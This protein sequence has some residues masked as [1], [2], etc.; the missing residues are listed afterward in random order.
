MENQFPEGN[1]LPPEEPNPRYPTGGRELLFFFLILID[2]LLLCNSVIFGGF[3]LGFAIFAGLS[4]LLAAGYLLLC[5]H[6]FC[7]YSG[8]LLGLSLM[9]CAGFA[10]SN[11]SF[12]KLILF[13]FLLLSSNLGL[14][15][16]AGQNRWR[17]GGFL[18]LLDAFRAAFAMGLGRL[19]KSMQGLVGAFR[20]S[21]AAG[22]KGGAVLIGLV[23]ALP[24]LAIVVSLLVSADAAFDALVSLLPKGNGHEIF[25]TVLLGSLL[26]CW[27]YTRATALHH[28][29]RAE[30]AKGREGKGLNALTV[31]TVLAAL[32]LVYCVYLFSQL[33]YFSGGFSGILPEGYS[34]AEYARRGFFEMAWLC[35]VNLAVI[36]LSVG[37]VKKEK[38]APL[39]TRLLCLFLGLVTLFLVCTASAKM[40][41]YIRSYGL[42]R[43]RVLTEVIMIWLGIATVLVTLWLFL[44]KLPYMKAVVLTALVMGCLV[45]WGDVDATVARYNVTAY[46]AGRL[47][48]VDVDYLCSLGEGA[49]PYIRR[50]ADD[51]NYK[52]ADAAKTHLLYLQ[53]QKP[54][55]L[56]YWNYSLHRALQVLEEFRS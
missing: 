9:I 43:L 50:L 32:S 28:S 24:I 45:L 3:Q 1:S 26:T 44:P 41:L 46:Q 25:P 36:A 29:P 16:L 8:M 39:S 37:L 6:R 55:D 33:A 40:F 4:I 19:P 7:L 13:L 35:A 51:R 11:D 34:A 38:A 20:N 53:L 15:L 49:L 18:N 52:V 48:T 21:G 14:C 42:T 12:V 56:R 2:G 54:E 22:K 47:E 27:L 17:S 23:I 5:G 30:A 31:N 10:H